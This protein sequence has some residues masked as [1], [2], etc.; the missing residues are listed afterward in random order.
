MNHW[1]SGEWVSFKHLR[2]QFPSAPRAAFRTDGRPNGWGHS[3]ECRARCTGLLDRARAPLGGLRLTPLPDS[4]PRAKER[5]APQSL[6]TAPAKVPG[7]L[8]SGGQV[9]GAA[10]LSGLGG[11]S[12][13]A[14]QGLG[15]RPVSRV[16]CELTACTEA[17]GQLRCNTPPHSRGR[18]VTVLS[19]DPEEDKD[20]AS[21]G[22]WQ[23]K[24][25]HH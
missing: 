4:D 5:N 20:A 10:E 3:A 11:H 19:P 1:H 15:A 21:A 25:Q 22:R 17:L 23:G 18:K 12:L 16:S 6:K 2:K 13:S 14:G 7:A 9:T 24:G 8:R